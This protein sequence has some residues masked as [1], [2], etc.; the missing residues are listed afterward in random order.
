MDLCRVDPSRYQSSP[1]MRYER[2]LARVFI[3]FWALTSVRCHY[4]KNA[5]SMKNENQTALFPRGNRLSNDYFTGNAFLQPLVGR[6]KN[7]DFVLGSVSFESSARTHWHTHPKGQILIV[8]DGE[9]YYQEK[10]RPAQVIRK[11]DTIT[12]PENVE[13]WHGAKATQ[14]MTHLALT[15]FWGD[16]NVVWLTPVTDEEYQAVH[17]P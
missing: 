2:F 15:H 1:V 11:G 4:F 13:H 3:G 17:H 10:G 9:G 16:R 12:I 8:T 7:N 6:D 14:A 5:E